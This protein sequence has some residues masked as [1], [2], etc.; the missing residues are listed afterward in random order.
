MKVEPA[1]SDHTMVK[2]LKEALK[3]RDNDILELK[4][5][6]KAAKEASY[7][8]N[9]VLGQNRVQYEK[10]KSLIFKEHR[11]EVKSLKKELGNEVKEKIRL[12]KELEEILIANENKVNKRSKKKKKKSFEEPVE[13]ELALTNSEI[14][15]SICA[16]PIPNFQPEYFCGERYN[17][18]CKTCK[19]QDSSW[20]Q[21]DPFSSFP[22][23]YQPASLVSHWI[24]PQPTLPQSPSLIPSFV[25]H[26]VKLPDPG[27]RFLSMEEVVEL[28]RNLFKEMRDNL[29][30]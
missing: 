17:P 26:C 8:L 24:P 11:A 27:D 10:E 30:F 6:L 5:A 25:S 14:F 7:K 18:V 4:V 20:S 21:D 3:D 1:S 12:E 2:E 13:T 22:S 19:T 9:G 23:E 16:Q 29:K 15:C 28:M